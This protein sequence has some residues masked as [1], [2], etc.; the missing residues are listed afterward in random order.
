MH[1]CSIEDLQH[2]SPTN[3]LKGKNCYYF[4][5]AF[6]PLFLPYSTAEPQKPIRRI[7]DNSSS[8]DAFYG[9]DHYFGYD[10]TEVGQQGFVCDCFGFVFVG[11]VGAVVDSS[12]GRHGQEDVEVAFIEVCRAVLRSYC[13]YCIHHRNMLFGVVVLVLADDVAGINQGSRCGSRH[14]RYPDVVLQ[15]VLKVLLESLAD[16]VVDHLD[17]IYPAQHDQVSLPKGQKAFLPVNGRSTVTYRPVGL[18]NTA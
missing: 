13:L 1:S 6:D 2:E 3:C 15:L 11:I 7:L 14:Y 12:V 18:R 4:V 16:V 8:S 5:E 9:V 10:G 17:G